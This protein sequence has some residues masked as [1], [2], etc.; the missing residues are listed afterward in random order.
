MKPLMKGWLGLAIMLSLPI[1]PGASS[2]TRAAFCTRQK[3]VCDRACPRV[4]SDQENCHK[5]CRSRAEDCRATGCYFF[6]RIGTQ[7]QQVGKS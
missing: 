7:C 6:H 5:I 3:A 4:A 1:A 2:E